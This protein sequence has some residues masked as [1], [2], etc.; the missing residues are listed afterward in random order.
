MTEQQALPSQAPGRADYQRAAALMLHQYRHDTLGW[1]SVM[2][3]TDQ[4]GRLSALLLAVVEIAGHSPE[5]LA[6]PKG[7]AGLQAVAA[8]MALDATPDDGGE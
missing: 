4:A 3:E 8:G 5:P 6:S 7:M 2:A 1:N